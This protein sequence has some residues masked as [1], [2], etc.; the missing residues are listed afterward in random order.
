VG[1]KVIRRQAQPFM[2]AFYLSLFGSQ[3]VSLG[4][5]FGACHRR[6]AI[7]ASHA[8]NMQ[9]LSRLRLN[10]RADCQLCD[11][12]PPRRNHTAPTT[13]RIRANTMKAMVTPI[14][15]ALRGAG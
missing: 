5:E 12:G 8:S 4:V 3:G 7:P 14:S 1:R 6:Y 2:N 11:P 15:L 9:N 10:R 13:I